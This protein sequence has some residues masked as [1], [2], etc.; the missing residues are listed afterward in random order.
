MS[1]KVTYTR[2]REN[3]PLVCLDGGP[4][5]GVDATPA[6]LFALADQLH[7][8]AAIANLRPTTGRNWHPE[9]R[10]LEGSEKAVAV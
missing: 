3:H 1:L 7:S 4:F 8:I 6:Q 9:V 10:V 2:T 5:N